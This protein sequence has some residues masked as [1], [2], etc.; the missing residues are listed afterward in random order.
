MVGFWK[1]MSC[2]TPN[3]RPLRASQPPDKPQT[4]QDFRKFPLRSCVRFLHTVCPKS[5]LLLAKAPILNSCS[6]PYINASIELYSKLVRP[7]LNPR[8]FALIIQLLSQ[9]LSTIPCENATLQV[10][11]VQTAGRATSSSARPLHAFFLM[12]GR[13]WD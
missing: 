3:S 6:I 12:L 13:C 11:S 1:N 4:G 9:R 5:P 8:P 7:P 10:A 2:K